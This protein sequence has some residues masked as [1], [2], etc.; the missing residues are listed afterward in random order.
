MVAD[1]VSNRFFVLNVVG[2]RIDIRP[3]EV[4]PAQPEV[5]FLVSEETSSLLNVV[6]IP[7]AC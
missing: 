1:G 2:E 4:Y 5:A 3:R 6:G 7:Y